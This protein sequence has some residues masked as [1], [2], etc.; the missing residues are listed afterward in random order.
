[1]IPIPLIL[2]LAQFAPSIMRYFGAGEGSAKAAEAI[3]N[4]AT[5]VTGAKSPEEALEALKADAAAQIAFREKVLEMDGELE[6]AYLS[7][8]ADAR[9]RDTAIQATG[10]R[11][12]RAD[13]M[14]VGA[15]FVVGLIVWKVWATPDLND[16][17]KGIVTLALGRFLGYTDQ[18]F[19]FEFGA[20]RKPFNA[21]K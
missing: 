7:D 18:I 5:S 20:V 12:I 11:N 8:V 19:Q 14:S 2:A 3:V 17:A 13:L 9:K 10:H 16:Y 4:V 1:M 15:F 6:K 21:P